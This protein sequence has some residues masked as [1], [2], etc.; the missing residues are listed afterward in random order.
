LRKHL[1]YL[2]NSG[3]T[4]RMWQRGRFSDAQTFQNDEAGWEALSAYLTASLHVPIF[5]LVDLIEEDFH[6]DTIPHVIGRTRKNLIERRLLQLYRDTPF[7]HASNQ[8]REKTGR[9]DDFMLFNA[10]T[11]APLLKTWVDIILNRQVPI[12]GV[13]S[14]ALLC[15]ALF[16]KL[17]LGKEP[18][19]FITH[20]SAGLRQSF[21]NDGYLRFSRL[22]VLPSQD[23]EEVAEIARTEIE[24][25]RLFLA[26]T[27]QLQ[28]GE[29]LH[30]VAL[31]NAETLSSMQAQNSFVESVDYRCIDPSEA[32]RTF[33]HMAERDQR[34]FDTLF[35]NV[36]ATNTPTSHYAVQEQSHAYTL[37]KARI[38]MYFLSGAMLVGS[39]FWSGANALDA[40]D[41]TNQVKLLQTESAQNERRYREIVASMPAA[42]I[43][44]HDM[45]SAV[46]LHEM[47]TNNRSTP[48]QI[49]QEISRVLNRSPQLYLEELSWE[50]SD[51]INPPA[52]AG[53]PAVQGAP[54]S[55]SASLIGVPVRPFEVVQMKGEIRPFKNDYR[56]ALD[57]VKQF[58]DALMMDKHIQVSTVREPIDIRSSVALSGQAGNLDNNTPVRFELKITW[59]P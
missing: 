17:K 22:T 10:L 36:L 58:S 20:Q 37:W 40:I 48:E 54:T 34:V 53:T 9:K 57:I 49:L 8:G 2:T 21:F 15:S 32:R 29:A 18:M 12:A 13:Y 30:I 4:A 19:L 51:N 28:R 38:I 31:D 6:R 27:R 25:T 42:E 41:A 50:V 24:K 47:I 14:T 35:L 56:S 45:K 26:N 23:P 5:I 1:F 46:D 33:G 16:K 11:N 7:R 44:P 3:L 43:N 52:A 59:S 39:L 55:L